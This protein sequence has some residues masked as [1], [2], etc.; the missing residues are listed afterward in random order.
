MSNTVATQGEAVDHGFAWLA[1]ILDYQERFAAVDGFLH[2]NYS[3]EYKRLKTCRNFKR[4]PKLTAE[5]R[6]NIVNW[7]S[8]AC[9]LFKWK[10]STFHFSV[11]C[12]DAYC[13]KAPQEICEPHLGPLATVCLYRSYLLGETLPSD[14]TETPITL[15]TFHRICSSIGSFS[16]LTAMWHNLSDVLQ[17]YYPGPSTM[18]FI[19]M[20][21]CNIA[22][23]D[24]LLL[25][26]LYRS[27]KV[28]LLYDAA[29]EA[30]NRYYS[31]GFCLNTPGSQLMAALLT[32]LLESCNLEE[33][34]REQMRSW[35]CETVFEV[36]GV[37]GWSELAG[38]YEFFKKDLQWLLVQA[39][40]GTFDDGRSV[41]G[42]HFHN[43]GN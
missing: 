21:L 24:K 30:S 29:R 18:E 4:Q 10:T 26:K 40:K 36:D 9:A 34:S 17:I 6:T 31:K 2:A 23:A 33:V 25:E 38:I 28:K 43:P 20:F 27:G 32:V 1:D 3:H 35:L 15:A 7:M 39:S 8:E 12:F 13:S 41:Y 42:I 11:A 16:S 37:N 19:E 22:E 14:P 5:L